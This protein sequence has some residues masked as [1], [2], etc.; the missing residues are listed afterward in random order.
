MLALCLKVFC[1]VKPICR[2][3]ANHMNVAMAAIGLDL[4]PEYLTEVLDNKD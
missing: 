3:E 1:T 4:D 2:K